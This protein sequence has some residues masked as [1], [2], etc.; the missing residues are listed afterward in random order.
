M[1]TLYDSDIVLWSEQQVDRLRR[2][3]RG[4]QPNDVDWENVAEEIE[5]VGRAEINAVRSLLLRALEHLL[6]AAAWPQAPSARKWLHEARVFLRDAQVEWAPSMMNRIDLADLYAKAL[7]TVRD[8]E[9]EEGPSG[10]LPAECPVLLA[11]L[12]EGD[13][14]QVLAPRFRTP[15]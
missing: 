11:E 6:N 14:I 2:I 15:G 12:M 3:A 1:S 8:L 5:S 13:V 9:F 10:P 4:E 7:I